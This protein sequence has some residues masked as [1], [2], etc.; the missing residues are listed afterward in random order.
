MFITQERSFERVVIRLVTDEEIQNPLF[1]DD[2]KSFARKL[3]VPRRKMVDWLVDGYRD[4]D[5]D[6]I[7]DEGLAVFVD[8]EALEEGEGDLVTTRIAD[9]LKDW[10][11]EPTRQGA[12]RLRP[13]AKERVRLIATLLRA[14]FPKESVVWGAP[15]TMKL[16][17]EGQS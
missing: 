15:V 9:W 14:I 8:F 1:R 3:R 13:E 4:A 10:L 17:G 6:I 12:S 2:V 5:V 11:S 7:N 16:I